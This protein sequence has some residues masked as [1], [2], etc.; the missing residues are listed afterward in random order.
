[1]ADAFGTI[2]AKRELPYARVLARSFSEF[3]PDLPFHV[4]LADEVEGC[5]DPSAEPFELLTLDDLR[6]ADPAGFRFLHRRQPLSYAAAP[7]FLSALM[8]R[9]FE[10]AVFIKQESLVLGEQQSVLR[11]L[12]ESSIV[13]TPHLLGPLEGEDASARELNILQSGAYNGGLVGVRSCESS[14]RF[15]A[16]WGDRV[17][18]RCRHAIGEGM[19]YEQRWL[20]LVPAYFRDARV[21]R[22]PGANVGHWNLPERLADTL[23]LL[24]FSG[25]DPHR[26]GEVTRYSPRL[27]VDE[28]GERAA[29]FASYATGLRTA[30][31]DEAQR[32]P[33]A[34]G[35]FANGV[36]IPDLVRELYADLAD[37]AGRFGDPFQTGAG[38]FYAWLNEP[39]VA[40]R[41][42]TRLWQAVHERRVDLREAFPDPLGADHDRFLAWIALNGVREHEID[43][44]FVPVPVRGSV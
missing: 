13:L 43:R 16:W 18:A 19:H 24:R 26:P 42:V 14:A 17:F 35:R 39:A 11:A 23:G 37:G 12:E 10:R 20:D 29:L 32:W 7:H 2:V 4:L 41:K 33:Y 30:G 31:W 25:F 5:F 27:S 3:H 40:G 38:S 15:L 21:L 44:A 22:E 1:M 28:L 8:D 6:L 36:P 34:Y 9:G